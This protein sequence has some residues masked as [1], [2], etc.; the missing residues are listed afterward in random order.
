MHNRNSQFLVQTHPTQ[1]KCTEK[2]LIRSEQPLSTERVVSTRRLQVVFLPKRE[3][4]S[5]N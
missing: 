3:T 1:V 2:A 4:S 5:E